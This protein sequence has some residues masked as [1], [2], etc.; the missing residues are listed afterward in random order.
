MSLIEQINSDFKQAMLNHD[1]VRK[2]TLNGLKSAIKY[3]EVEK[4]AGSV[5]DDQEIEAVIAREVK[6][7]NDAIEVYRQA[8]DNERADKEVAERDILMVYLPKQ[9]TADELRAKVAEIIVNGGYEKQDFGRIMG[10]A[11]TE[12]GNA[13]DGA[14][15]AAMVREYFAQ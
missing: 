2:T 15:I 11:K 8:G 9:L 3:R 1:E 5:L 6:S 4:G 13:A 10:Q 14:A 12:I 7:R